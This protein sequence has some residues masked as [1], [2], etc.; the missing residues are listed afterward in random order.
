MDYTYIVLGKS[1]AAQKRQSVGNQW[2]KVL[3]N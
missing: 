2:R 1:N 3:V